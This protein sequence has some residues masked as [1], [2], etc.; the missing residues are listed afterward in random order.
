MDLSDLM[1][2]MMAVPNILGLYILQSEVASDL[3]AYEKG[4]ASGEI[5]PVAGK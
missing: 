2:L 5:R 4:L 1:I 3:L